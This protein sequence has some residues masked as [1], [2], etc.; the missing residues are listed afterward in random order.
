MVHQ[1]WPLKP[2]ATL[3]CLPCTRCL[4]DLD[5]ESVLVNWDPAENAHHVSQLGWEDIQSVFR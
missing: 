2:V 5:H 1:H 3:H 4:N